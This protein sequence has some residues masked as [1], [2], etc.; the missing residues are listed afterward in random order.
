[1]ADNASIFHK[2]SG[3]SDAS[4]KRSPAI[5]GDCP[6]LD[7]YTGARSGV[8]FWDDFLSQDDEDATDIGYERYIDT[9][10]TIR[11]LVVDT[12]A[13][14]TGSRGGVLRLLL[15]GTD[16]DAPVIQYQTANGA[17]PF[18]ISATAGASWKTYFEARIRKTSIADDVQ[19]LA[20]GL[21]QVDRAADNG[22]LEDDTGDI[23][24]SISFIGWRVKHVNGGTTGQNALLDFVYQDAAQTAPTVVLASAATLVASTWV[25]VG[26]VYDPAAPAEKRIKLFVNNVEQSTYVTATA[27]A[28]A[29][30]PLSDALTLVASAKSGTGTA[31]N[32]DI[33]WWGVCQLYD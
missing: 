20:I 9:S 13:E 3:T 11:N 6:I 31:S 25:K 29:T 10:N 18:M 17:A 27:L 19:A 23:V 32:L 33:D 7:L 28:A 26:F 16:N 1:M 24:D 4:H 12:T 21:A 15:D 8:Y 14:A 22:L 30:F 5:W 2:Q